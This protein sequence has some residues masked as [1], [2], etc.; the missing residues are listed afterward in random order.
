M[1]MS[2]CLP[3]SFAT[4]AALALP[5]A[6]Q[7]QVT[8]SGYLDTGVFRDYDK[9][10]KLGTIQRSHLAV[11]GTEDL[12]GGL[13]ANFRLSTRFELDTGQSE[14]AGS[15]PFWHDESTVGL[16]G[17]WGQLRLGRALS[18]MWSQEWKFDAFSNF[19]RIASTA[20]HMAHYYTPTDRASNNGAAEYGRMTNG[21][22]Y[23]SPT[24]DGFSFNASASTERTQAPGRDGRGG[25]VALNYDQGPVAAMVGY[26]RNGSGDK[27]L[28]LGGL[29]RL[30]AATLM[31]AYDRSRAG[32]S[33][34][35]SRMVSVG[36]SYA[37]GV[38]TL[39]ASYGRQRLN[40]GV[41]HHMASLG[42]EYHL[43][44]RTMLYASLG[45][46]RYEHNPS[47]TAFGVGVAHA[48]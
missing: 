30:G 32:S 27:D 22:Y 23:D 43:S 42:A 14:G 39:R 5:A 33:P 41:T 4:L 48:F 35:T 45:H 19:N 29:Y 9:T 28:F 17:G 46:Q 20:W 40:D 26:E 13:K 2:Q 8:I 7:S 16:Q 31:M 34:D 1:R 3:L 6:A 24:W 18:A 12:G 25:S 38:T 36:G 10:R 44:K 37:L 11:A 15:K 47:R 21:I